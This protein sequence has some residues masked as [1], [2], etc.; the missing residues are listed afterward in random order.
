MIDF[1]VDIDEIIQFFLRD[2]GLFGA[3]INSLINFK[4]QNTVSNIYY[5]AR[6]Q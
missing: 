3:N 4:N 2:D 6:F 5:E 1:P